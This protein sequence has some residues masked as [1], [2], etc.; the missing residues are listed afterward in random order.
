MT[1]ECKQTEMDA[2]ILHQSSLKDAS[3]MTD[4]I[5]FTTLV[6]A[7]VQVNTGIINNEKNPISQ[8]TNLDSKKGEFSSVKSFVLSCD[9]MPFKGSKKHR[10]AYSEGDCKKLDAF[11]RRDVAP[12]RSNVHFSL[13]SKKVITRGISTKLEKIAFKSTPAVLAHSSKDEIDKQKTPSGITGHKCVWQQQVK[14]LQQRLKSLGKQVHL[15]CTDQCF[16][17]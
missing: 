15:K 4:V 13:S 16:V 5:N 2:P 9:K 14:T 1:I 7:A 17:G 11:T 6:D 3:V 8:K 12:S 10:R